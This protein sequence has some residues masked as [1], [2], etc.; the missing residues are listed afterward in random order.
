MPK[1]SYPINMSPRNKFDKILLEEKIL[2]FT[3]VKRLYKNTKENMNVNKDLCI[4]NKS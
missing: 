4:K 2:L 3:L 1:K